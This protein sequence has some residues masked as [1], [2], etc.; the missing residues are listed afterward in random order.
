MNV[1]VVRKMGESEG[2]PLTLA[3]PSQSVSSAASARTTRRVASARTDTSPTFPADTA[4]TTLNLAD[5][6]KWV[7]VDNKGAQVPDGSCC[8]RLVPGG[9]YELRLSQQSLAVHSADCPVDS[10]TVVRREEQIS[11]NLRGPV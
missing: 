10:F 6:S 7:F 5:P 2:L 3:D 8:N 1:V 9:V 4:A 11:H